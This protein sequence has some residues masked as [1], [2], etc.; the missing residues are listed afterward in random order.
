MSFLSAEQAETV[1]DQL[2]AIASESIMAP[3]IEIMA[4]CVHKMMAD[5]D[6]FG[7]IVVLPDV[8]ERALLQEAMPADIADSVQ[9]KVMTDY[10]RARV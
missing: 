10:P 1:H 7:V 2:H 6:G 8:D 9:I 5:P 3:P 4:S